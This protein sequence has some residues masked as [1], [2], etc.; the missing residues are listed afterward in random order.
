MASEIC[1]WEVYCQTDS[2]YREVWSLI[3]PTTCPDNNQHTISTSPP[4][5]I[6]NTIKSNKVKI[7]EESDGPTQGIYKFKGYTIDIPSGPIGNVTTRLYT[8]PYPITLINGWF[9]AHDGMEGDC[10]ELTVADNTVIGAIAAPL[11][12]GNTEIIVTSTVIDNLYKG[13][14]VSVTDGVNL[15]E[16]GQCVDI[17]IINSKITVE[18]AASNSFSPLSPTYVML[19]VKVV[20]NFSIPVANQ[21]YAFAEKKVGGKFLP[22]NIP[23]NVRYTN[24]SGN[25]KTFCYNIEY[26]Y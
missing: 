12:S 8:F 14:Y 1:L 9:I 3:E 26:L 24:Y 18:T 5:R 22:A 21:R 25:A 4:P 23:V 6:I 2:I 19:A 20:E 7:I 10:V 13:Y 16:L 17:D 11:Y 15:D